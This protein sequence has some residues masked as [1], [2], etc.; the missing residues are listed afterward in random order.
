[1]STSQEVS[2]YET[3]II[4]A[5][6][7][8]Y[9]TTQPDLRAFSTIRS[10]LPEDMKEILFDLLK[11]YIGMHRQGILGK[12]PVMEIYK[13]LPPLFYIL[14]RMETLYYT[15]G[16][17]LLTM[18]KI[19]LSSDEEK[20]EM[21]QIA[22]AKKRFTQYFEIQDRERLYKAKHELDVY[23]SEF[24]ASLYSPGCENEIEHISLRNLTIEER[25]AIIESPAK[26]HIIDTLDRFKKIYLDNFTLNDLRNKST[27]A[28]REVAPIYNF[29]MSMGATFMRVKKHEQPSK[30]GKGIPERPFD[31]LLKDF[32][33]NERTLRNGLSNTTVSEEAFGN[34]TTKLEELAGRFSQAVNDYDKYIQSAFDPSKRRVWIPFVPPEEQGQQE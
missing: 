10:S 28:I 19:Q 15:A 23:T 25:K 9:L 11:T 22:S 29:G 4:Y 34:G 32:S 18:R 26:D 31:K 2:S 1:M 13:R 17:K 7:M 14:S 27:Q 33:E 30:T 20:Y 24:D 8:R 12:I 3:T 5:G 16:D 6:V 21:G